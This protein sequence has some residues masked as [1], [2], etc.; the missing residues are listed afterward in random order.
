MVELKCCPFCGG[1][2]TVIAESREEGQ[3][4]V[5]MV[6]CD[7]CYCRTKAHNDKDSAM[8]KWN[9]RADE[10]GNNGKIH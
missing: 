9:L 5:Y 2:A 7:W 3:K 4:R 10:R 6:E 1:T 8:R